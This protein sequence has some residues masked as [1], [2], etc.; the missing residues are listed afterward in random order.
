MAELDL[1]APRPVPF[2]L[3][4]RNEASGLL[5]NLQRRVKNLSTAQF[6]LV[7]GA[8]VLLLDHLIAPK[9]MSFASKALDKVLPGSRLPLPPPLPPPAAIAAAKGYFS[10][11][12]NMAGWNRGMS[13]YG[14]MDGFYWHGHGGP[15]RNWHNDPWNYGNLEYPWAM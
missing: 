8:G 14:G 1:N 9:G 10:G 7:A 5:G 4:R 6:V 2:W 12:N 13:P 11:A 15:W 3:R